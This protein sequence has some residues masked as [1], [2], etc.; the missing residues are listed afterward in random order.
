MCWERILL[1]LFFS[2]LVEL[3][4]LQQ[5]AE[6]ASQIS[7]V[8]RI[9]TL[10]S[11]SLHPNLWHT[12]GR[13]FCWFIF[14]LFGGPFGLA[15]VSLRYLALT[16]HSHTLF[17]EGIS[18]F[19]GRAVGLISWVMRIFTSHFITLR[20]HRPM[21]GT[22]LGGDSLDSFF[23]AHYWAGFCWFLSFFL[24]FWWRF[25]LWMQKR[26]QLVEFPA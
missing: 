21:Y 6:L 7:G 2:F 12:I 3:L 8:M 10:H 22:L 14:F 18:F 26:R 23:L 11:I 17:W 15:R 4:G 24:F 20:T 25:W 19:F 16:L 5:L 9:F 13:G 1:I